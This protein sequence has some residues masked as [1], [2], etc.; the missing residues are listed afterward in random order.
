MAEN[1]GNMLKTWKDYL[2]FFDVLDRRTAEK[3]LSKL[4]FRIPRRG[5]PMIRRLVLEQRVDEQS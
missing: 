2:H 5:P 1:T 3:K 4:G